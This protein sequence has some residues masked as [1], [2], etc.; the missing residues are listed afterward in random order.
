MDLEAARARGP[1]ACPPSPPS[2][3]RSP[4]CGTAASCS[5]G[6]LQGLVPEPE[7]EATELAHSYSTRESSIDAGAEPA[8]PASRSPL[9]APP[10]PDIDPDERPWV[11]SSSAFSCGP[12]P[13]R[14]GALPAPS[15][16]AAAG[17]FLGIVAYGLLVVAPWLLIPF[18]KLS[19][20][21]QTAVVAVL[22]S[23]L[24][25]FPVIFWSLFLRRRPGEPWVAAALLFVQ[26]LFW[27]TGVATAAGVDLSRAVP[28]WAGLFGFW[29]YCLLIA[30]TAFVSWRLWALHEA[31]WGGGPFLRS[32]SWRRARAC[33]LF[34]CI[35][36]LLLVAEMGYMIGMS[37]LD[38]LG[39][40]YTWT[41][42]LANAVMSLFIFGSSWAL[43]ALFGPS[44]RSAPSAFGL[45]DLLPSWRP[46]LRA[47]PPP[48]RP[49]LLRLADRAFDPPPPPAAPASPSLGPACPRSVEPR[50]RP[51]RGA[52]A[53]PSSTDGDVLLFAYLLS[54]NRVFKTVCF[55]FVHSPGVFFAG[56]AVDAVTLLAPALAFFSDD[57]RIGRTAL[58]LAQRFFLAGGVSAA[59]AA[60]SSLRSL[61]PSGRI[62]RRLAAAS[63]RPSR[64]P[65]IPLSPAVSLR[66]SPGHAR[67]SAP[68]SP[69]PFSS[70]QLAPRRVYPS[71]EPP[72][73]RP[74]RPSSVVLAS[75]PSTSRRP[76]SIALTPLPSNSRSPSPPT[77][78]GGL[79]GLAPAYL[80]L[81][82]PAAL[83]PLR[84]PLYPDGRSLGGLGLGEPYPLRLDRVSFEGSSSWGGGPLGPPRPSRGAG[85]AAPRRPPGPADVAA[86]LR[87][88]DLA[89]RV[90][91]KVAVL[92]LIQARPRTPRPPDRVPPPALIRV[93]PQALS[94]FLASAQFALTVSLTSHPAPTRAGRAKDGGERR[95][96]LAFSVASGLLP[97]A[98]FLAT[99]AALSAARPVARRSFAH[100]AGFLVANRVP[101]AL[102]LGKVVLYPFIVGLPRF[103]NVLAFTTPRLYEHSHAH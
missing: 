53:A 59:A 35:P 21:C 64:R 10:A 6:Q 87:A 77:G 24:L 15:A 9:K 92:M 51:E 55:G 26:L 99:A 100:A 41:Q 68:A 76:S 84:A 29:W 31:P 27:G 103:V 89:A 82:P 20:V 23:P 78:G 54:S 13:E 94:A 48:D 19:F 11:R 14:G 33:I 88:A 2:S 62:S 4:I 75:L 79:P 98:L 32:Q 39:R 101:L 58:A 28:G 52:A 65:S 69:R 61:S 67:R 50:R 36:S 25:G 93:P 102:L 71:D 85:A 81:L 16:A 5:H 1:C 37:L 74:R 56:L 17:S 46:G 73:G 42:A 40:R 22:V 7:P 43:S 44:L 57:G 63:R 18:H 96:S 80:P 83:P 72:G 47:A 90:H 66:G 70:P 45:R 60:S 97:L 91:R 38:G 12:E 95:A 8:T 30:A 86:G 34:L 3:S 49:F